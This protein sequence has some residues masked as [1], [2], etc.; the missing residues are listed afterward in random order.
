ML[1]EMERAKQ[2]EHPTKTW[3]DYIRRYMEFWRVS[4]D[5]YEKDQYRLRIKGNRLTRVYLEMAA[6]TVCWGCISILYW[7]HNSHETSYTMLMSASLF[8]SQFYVGACGDLMALPINFEILVSSNREGFPHTRRCFLMSD[9]Y[10]YVCVMHTRWRVQYLAR[11][12]MDLDIAN[13]RLETVD[14]EKRKL[15]QERDEVGTTCCITTLQYFL[16]ES[17][18]NRLVHF[19]MHIAWNTIGCNVM[20]VFS[21]LCS[22]TLTWLH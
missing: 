16:E 11:L 18:L 5:V 14:E 12:R 20:S 22:C 6:K 2:W 15:M 1:M 7:V 4:E 21:Q 3:W 17:W 13:K 9:V 19:K 8:L 10:V